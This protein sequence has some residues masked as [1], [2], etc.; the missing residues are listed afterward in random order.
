MPEAEV[1]TTYTEAQKKAAH[2]A[3]YIDD[4]ACNV[5]GI[6]NALHEAAAAWLG[7]GSGTDGANTCAPVKIIMH[8]LNHLV[9]HKTNCMTHEEWLKARREC[10]EISGRKA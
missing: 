1:A 8:Q 3:T 2:N 7:A 5:S 9:F 6:A 10:E 4:G